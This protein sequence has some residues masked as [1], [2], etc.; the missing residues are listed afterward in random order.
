MPN[1]G[2]WLGWRMQ[3][4][5]FLPRYAPKLWL[6]PTVVVVL[7]SPRGVGVIAVTTMYL[8]LWMSLSRSRMERCTLAL[9]L[10]Y[11]S[12]SSGRM[13]ASEAIWSMGIGVAAWATSISLGT[14]VRKF[15]NLWGT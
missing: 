8:P 5:T 2:P 3:V 10:P 1:V 7:P 15:V 13:P 6:S 11:S 9:V 4:N 12:N 14:G